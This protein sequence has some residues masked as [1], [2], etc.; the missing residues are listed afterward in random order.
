[1]VLEKST[2]RST[3]DLQ[4]YKVGGAV[5]DSILGIASRDA[6]WVV[7]GATPELML[8]LGLK[9]VG[10]DFPVF[11][12]FESGEEYAL[13][14][15]ERKV[16]RGYKG[17]EVE[18]GVDVTLEE[19]LYRRDLTINAI[20]QAPD[21]TLIDPYGGRDDIVRRTLRHVSPHFVEDPLRVVRVARFAA[22]LQA[23]GFSVDE[24]TLTLM[25]QMVAGGELADLAAERVWREV[26]AAL[27]Q[28]APEMFFSVLHQC[29]ALKVLI[30]EFD[31]F[32]SSINEAEHVAVRSLRQAVRL[33]KRLE[34][35]FSVLACC[36]AADLRGKKGEVLV[37]GICERLRAPTRCRQ[38]SLRLLRHIDDIRC[39]DRLA[40]KDV[41][42]LVMR[43][44]GLQDAE[45]FNTFTL[46]SQAIVQ[47]ERSGSGPSE[48]I[49][50]FLVACR[51]AMLKVSAKDFIDQFKGRELGRAIFEAQ[52]DK[53]AAVLG[54]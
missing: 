27:E 30:P 44:Q 1:M 18:A 4:R 54:R 23:Y 43:V 11:I 17:F 10:K 53:I 34:V 8:K 47:A 49:A 48:D 37:E 26:N 28:D 5:R 3:A 12:D 24:T 40:A 9:Q 36:A 52:V 50:H 39:L 45:S 21:G 15:N 29:G 25:R 20:A 6:D 7:V 33:S 41:A 46:A 32:F 51:D 35:R 13:A 2:P 31:D 16:G 19:D 38:L 14:R 22:Q 42:Q